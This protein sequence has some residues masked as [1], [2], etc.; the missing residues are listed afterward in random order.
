MVQLADSDIRT[1]EV[2]TWT[3]VHVLHYMGSSCSQ[4]LRIVLNLKGIMWQSHLIPVI[5]VIAVFWARGW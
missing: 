5:A 4:K 3:G 2:L 1:R